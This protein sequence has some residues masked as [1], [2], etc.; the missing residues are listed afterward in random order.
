MYF[1]KT[2]KGKLLFTYARNGEDVK[3]PERK[4]FIKKLKLEKVREM[5]N[6]KL[7]KNIEK[8]IKLGKYL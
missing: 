7:F 4:I 1:S 8:R 5:D 6:K 3:I 2:V